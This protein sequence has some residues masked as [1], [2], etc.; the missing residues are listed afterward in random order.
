MVTYEQHKKFLEAVLNGAYAELR[1]F[2][3]AKFGISTRN[4][5]KEDS[6]LRRYDQGLADGKVMLEIKQV[7]S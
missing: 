1:G 2:N 3:E 4:L 5:F 6:L 7:P